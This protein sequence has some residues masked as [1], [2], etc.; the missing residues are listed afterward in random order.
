VDTYKNASIYMYAVQPSDQQARDRAHREDVYGRCGGQGNAARADF[1]SAGLRQAQERGKH[2]AGLGENRRP[3]HNQHH[4]VM[5]KNFFCGGALE[6]GLRKG[7]DRDGLP[8]AF[9]RDVEVVR[10]S[11]YL[12]HPNNG[13]RFQS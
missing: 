12:T 13:A 11:K 2:V 3:M 4:Q 5:R 7:K 9:Q 1:S 6:G 10:R 8:D